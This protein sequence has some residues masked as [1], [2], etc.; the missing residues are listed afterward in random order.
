MFLHRTNAVAM[1]ICDHKVLQYQRWQNF[2]D[3]GIDRYNQSV[4][5]LLSGSASACHGLVGLKS[6]QEH[7]KLPGCDRAMG[8]LTFTVHDPMRMHRQHPHAWHSARKGA[9]NVRNT[10]ARSYIH[11]GQSYAIAITH[12]VR[13]ALYRTVHLKPWVPPHM[14]CGH[15]CA[16]NI[17]TSMN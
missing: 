15:I 12:R 14:V 13:T 2:G 3:D 10:P 16:G 17:A 7:K 5:Q 8:P 11:G 6:C 1:G 4:L 9:Q